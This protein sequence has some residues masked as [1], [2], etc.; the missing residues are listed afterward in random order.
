MLKEE[1]ARRR[2]DITWT[3]WLLEDWAVERCW[4]EVRTASLDSSV[5]FSR[6]A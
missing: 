1:D 6:R 4:G 3:T 2:L 5:L